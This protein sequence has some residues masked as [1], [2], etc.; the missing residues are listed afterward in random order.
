MLAVTAT[1]VMPASVP[2]M[3]ALIVSVAV[4]DW[5]PAVFRVAENAWMPP[6]ALMKA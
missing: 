5:L 3:L 4:I 1:T 6:S 2:L